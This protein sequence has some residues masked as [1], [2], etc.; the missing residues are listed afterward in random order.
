MTP[1]ELFILL[2]AFM[3]TIT[4]VILVLNSRALVACHSLTNYQQAVSKAAATLLNDQPA[5]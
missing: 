4:V 5:G 2:R 3:V 1:R